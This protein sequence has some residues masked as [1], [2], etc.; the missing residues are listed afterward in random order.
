MHIYS[1]FSV[2][3]AFSALTLLAEWQEGH[4]GL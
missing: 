3:M 2:F 1:K 4:L